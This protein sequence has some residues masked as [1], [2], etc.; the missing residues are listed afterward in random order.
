MLPHYFNRDYL[1]KCICEGFFPFLLADNI[2]LYVEK[3]ARRWTFQAIV[4][5]TVSVDTFFMLSYVAGFIISNCDHYDLS[6]NLQA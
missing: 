1:N 5:A 6:F 4:G 2:L 3:N